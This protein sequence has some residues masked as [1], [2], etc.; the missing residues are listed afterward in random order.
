LLSN[1]ADEIGKLRTVV[2]VVCGDGASGGER[3]L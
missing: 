2:Q 1:D 3:S